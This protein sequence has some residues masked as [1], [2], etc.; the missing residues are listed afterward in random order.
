M[1]QE[2]G[3]LVFRWHFLIIYLLIAGIISYQLVE[4]KIERDTPEAARTTAY[5]KVK[6]TKESDYDIDVQDDSGDESDFVEPGTIMEDV[7]EETTS[8]EDTTV[9]TTAPVTT[10]SS[11][12]APSKKPAVS[13]TVKP[14]TTKKAEPSTGE[15][16][17]AS[18]FEPTTAS[19]VP[20]TSE[21]TETP[22]EP[23]TEPDAVLVTE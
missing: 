17:T 4:F 19:N 6:V 23:G 5:E 22:T 2:N 16:T 7:P 1:A 10:T 20:S 3:K 13:T 15:P 18:T 14:T 9:T 12:I 8:Q 21:T 11:A